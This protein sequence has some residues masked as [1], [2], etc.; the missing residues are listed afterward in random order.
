MCEATNSTILLGWSVNPP[1]PLDLFWTN[2]VSTPG[3]LFKETHRQIKKH[4]QA[5]RQRK[6][7]ITHCRHAHPWPGAD[8]PP[9]PKKQYEPGL[10]AYLAHL[11]PF[12]VLL[13]IPWLRTDLLS[14]ICVH[15][16]TA[17][18][19]ANSIE[20][21][22]DAIM[23]SQDHTTPHRCN[24]PVEPWPLNFNICQS[25]PSFNQDPRCWPCLIDHPSLT[26]NNVIH[27]IQMSLLVIS[28]QFTKAIH[29]CL[30]P[31]ASVL[32]VSIKARPSSRTP[33]LNFQPCTNW[34]SE[35]WVPIY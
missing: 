22:V 23:Q 4:L 5:G 24:P 30:E 18:S 35:E 34:I 7:D 16:S 1:K 25:I 6:P 31:P 26:W 15:C 21:W 27:K 2:D 32:P 8:K 12:T 11:R 13:G 14:M 10:K 3:P 9:I 17:R 28:S 29:Y 19:A 20:L 33:H